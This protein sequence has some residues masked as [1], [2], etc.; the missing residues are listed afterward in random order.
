MNS[1]PA[2]KA[3]HGLWRVAALMRTVGV[4]ILAGIPAGLLAGGV[5]S[6]IAMRISAIATGPLCPGLVTA[7]NNRCGE[8][9][10]DGTIGLLFFGGVFS[11]IVGSLLY[12]GMRP[13]LQQLG[14][15]KG[16][17][18]GL[19]LLATFGSR[20]IE[21]DNPDFHRFGPPLLSIAL[22]A[23]LFPLFGLIIAQL[24]DRLNR[25]IPSIPITRPV[26]L[27]TVA[28]YVLAGLASLPGFFFAASAV[29]EIILTLRGAPPPFPIL[30]GM[31][32]PLYLYFV[33]VSPI[34]Y[35]RVRRRSV[36]SELT[37]TPARMQIIDAS[38]AVL[39]IPALAGLVLTIQAIAE[40]LRL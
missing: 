20:I 21:A 36:R 12:G 40:I 39:G 5:G 37:A 31:F 1:Q 2:E 8:I 27:R 23:V 25:A 14:P 7:N 38:V 17:V 16:L 10:L 33:V 22:F 29:R 35:A 13:W 32:A 34:A 4:F 15:W 6:R 28:G 26:R 9:T 18:F 3:P 24:Y 19:L 11:G 30:P